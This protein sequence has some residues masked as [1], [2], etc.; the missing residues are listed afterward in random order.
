MREIAISKFK[1]TC[2]AVIEDVQKTRRAIR[3][4]KRGKTIVELF[5]CQPGCWRGGRKFV[6]TR[7]S[8]SG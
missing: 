8:R 4:T 2:L 1:A 7:L 3:V 6:S 5:P